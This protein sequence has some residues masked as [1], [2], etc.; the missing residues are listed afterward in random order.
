M[1]ASLD[2]IDSSRGYTLDN[3]Q[4]VHKDLN[5]M[6]TNYPNDYFIKMCKYVANNNKQNRC[7]EK[8]NYVTR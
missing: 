3:I 4:W 1:T 7:N 8:R 2:R 6:K 5:K